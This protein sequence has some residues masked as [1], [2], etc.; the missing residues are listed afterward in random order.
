MGILKMVMQRRQELKLLLLSSDSA[1]AKV[2]R[3][4]EAPLLKVPTRAF[5]VAIFHTEE[6]YRLKK[7]S[8]EGLQEIPVSRSRHMLVFCLLSAVFFFF[9]VFFPQE[10]EERD[11]LKA[12]VRAA[13]QIHQSEPEGDV[14]LFLPH[15]EEIDVA[16]QLLRKEAAH[17][18]L[19]ELQ[20][21]ALYV[22]LPLMDVQRV[23]E[24]PQPIRNMQQQMQK[25]SRKIVVASSVAETAVCIDGITYVIDAGVE[26]QRVYNPRLCLNV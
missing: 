1:A 8:S 10:R 26:K 12:A 14:L 4:F 21:R 11:Y 2:Q 9:F 17:M 16:C 15:E 18:P 25:Q 23:F 22:G 5:P 3:F 6:D 19:G 13:V 20:V 24:P 7:T